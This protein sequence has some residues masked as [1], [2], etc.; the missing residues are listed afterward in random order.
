MNTTT[1]AWRFQSWTAFV[2]SF[3]I[4]AIGILWLPL[5]IWP[6]AF[7]GLGFLFTVA[8]CFTLAKTIRDDADSTRVQTDG[9]R[10]A[11]RTAMAGR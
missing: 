7:L 8:Q 10:S 9:E 11:Y 6:K 1:N 5:T 4:T 3:G 2:L